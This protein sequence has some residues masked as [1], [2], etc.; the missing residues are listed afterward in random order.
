MATLVVRFRLLEKSF[1]PFELVP[2]LSQRCSQLGVHALQLVDTLIVGLRHHNHPTRVQAKTHRRLESC[3]RSGSTLE[4]L[5]DL[6]PHRRSPEA[7]PSKRRA[8][9]LGKIQA[10]PVIILVRLGLQ[11]TVVTL[12]V[13][14]WDRPAPFV[15]E[16]AGLA[17]FR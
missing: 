6:R 8:G 5:P 17:A 13:S 2:A 16:G 3:K 10:S 12:V 15:L 11:R 4:A 7:E 1:E 9:R 14:P